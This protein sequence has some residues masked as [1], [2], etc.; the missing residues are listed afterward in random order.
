MHFHSLVEALWTSTAKNKLSSK[1]RSN[2][3]FSVLFVIFFPPSLFAEGCTWEEGG[4]SGYASPQA[5]SDSAQ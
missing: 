3:I 4:K 5:R 2:F 1:F